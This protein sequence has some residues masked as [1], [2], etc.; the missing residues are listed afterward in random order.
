[1]LD[2]GSINKNDYNKPISHNNSPSKIYELIKEHE[3]NFPL[4]PGAFNIV[5]FILCP[6]SLLTY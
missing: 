1:M 3:D 4:R 2:Q 6:I 5:L